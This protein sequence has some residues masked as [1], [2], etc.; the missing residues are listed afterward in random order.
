[1]A[2][3]RAART[4]RIASAGSIPSSTSS[5]AP[6]V[7]ARPSPPRQWMRTSRPSRNSARISAPSTSHRC[8]NS[9]SG[10]ETSAIGRWNQRMPRRTV[11]SPR[12]ST[13]RRV[14]SS[15]STRVT[16]AAAPQS[17]IASRS[18]FRSRSQEPVAA[19]SSYFPGQNVMP[20]RPS[21]APTAIEAILS[22]CVTEVRFTV[23]PADQADFARD[24]RTLRIV[25]SRADSSWNFVITNSATAFGLLNNWTRSGTP[26]R[27]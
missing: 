2:P 5:L 3:G 23:P 10:V 26:R 16:T 11:S 1:M 4:C 12:R 25:S 27:R 13:R 14:S 9:L 19:F 17:R 18:T 6:I 7:P 20:T 21:V 8:S 15:D 24:G 22:G